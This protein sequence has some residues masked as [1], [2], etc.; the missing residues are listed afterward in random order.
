MVLMQRLFFLKPALRRDAPYAHTGTDHNATMAGG[1][2]F[3]ALF[4]LSVL[5]NVYF[6]YERWRDDDGARKGKQVHSKGKHDARA[7]PVND[8]STQT[9]AAGTHS[10]GPGGAHVVTQQMSTVRLVRSFN[11]LEDM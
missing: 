4:S 1:G 5:L 8:G 10:T 9:V 3:S 2:L 11:R 6:I 7:K